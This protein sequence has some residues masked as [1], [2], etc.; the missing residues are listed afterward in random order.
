MRKFLLCLLC[1]SMGT[2]VFACSASSTNLGG[3]KGKVIDAITGKPVAGVEVVATASNESNIESEQRYLKYSTKTAQDGS[4]QIKGIRGKNYK[5][6]VFKKG[7]L[8]QSRLYDEPQPESVAVDIPYE[9]NM[10]IKNPIKLFPSPPGEG[11]FIYTDK[12]I[13]LELKPYKTYEA[14]GRPG[15]FGGDRFIFFEIDD[16]R[17]IQDIHPRP[18]MYLVFWLSRTEKFS[19][20]ESSPTTLHFLFRHSDMSH[21]EDDAESSGKYYSTGYRRDGLTTPQY[22]GVFLSHDN[23]KT[24]Y[25]DNNPNR[26]YGFLEST[27]YN[28]KI[29][30]VDIRTLPDGY[31]VIGGRNYLG[32]FSFSDKGKAWVLKIPRRN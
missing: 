8:S 3:A 10:I 4:F 19:S 14:P 25:E 32:E 24:V 7:F 9:S 23:S 26:F 18:A 15:S 29:V 6:F 20:G 12:Y 21:F 30:V 1:F 27:I 28:N 16:I 31:Y 11:I 2:F 22:Y 17:D 13:P 5:I